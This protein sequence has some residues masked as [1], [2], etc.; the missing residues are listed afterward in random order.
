MPGDRLAHRLCVLGA[1]PLLAA[2]DQAAAPDA[3]TNCPMAEFF[4]PVDVEVGNEL[5]IG[6]YLGDRVAAIQN[7]Q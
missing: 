5:W 3:F 7:P 6:S 1:A 2:C 4:P